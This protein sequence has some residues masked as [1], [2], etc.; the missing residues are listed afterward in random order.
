LF[1]SIEAIVLA[2]PNASLVLAWVLRVPIFGG[3]SLFTPCLNSADLASHNFL[4]SCPRNKHLYL[5]F[6]LL[7][8]SI[9]FNVLAYQPY[10]LHPVAVLENELDLWIKTI[11]EGTASR[12]GV[13]KWRENGKSGT[14]RNSVAELWRG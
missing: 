14:S 9:Q 4:F 11:S 2:P 7:L 13:A 12:K 5:I 3:R 10:A 6:T 8:I 1:T